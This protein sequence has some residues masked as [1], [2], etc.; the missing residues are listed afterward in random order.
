MS[1]EVITYV[2]FLHDPKKLGIGYTGTIESACKA[3]ARSHRKMD[4]DV[5]EL[6]ARRDETEWR[7]R[8]TKKPVDFDVTGL[9][10]SE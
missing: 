6:I 9:R 5:F 7:I 10:G 8:L 2:R 3:F 1:D 4:L